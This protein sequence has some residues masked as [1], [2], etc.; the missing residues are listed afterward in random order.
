MEDAVSREIL[1]DEIRTIPISTLTTTVSVPAAMS[2]EFE[3]KIDGV[4]IQVVPFY[5]WALASG[6][7]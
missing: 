6:S 7:D 5:K 1:G 4:Q 3:E 2:E